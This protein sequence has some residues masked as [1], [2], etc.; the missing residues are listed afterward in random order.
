MRPYDPTITYLGTENP[1]QN[2]DDDTGY[3]SL[4]LGRKAF[5]I[6]DDVAAMMLKSVARGVSKAQVFENV[7]EIA[8]KLATSRLT[9]D[10]KVPFRGLSSVTDDALPKWTSARDAESYIRDLRS[11]M[12]GTD[13]RLLGRLNNVYKINRSLAGA[14]QKGENKFDLKLSLVNHD[15]FYQKVMDKYGID[16]LPF[17]KENSMAFEFFHEFGHADVYYNRELVPKLGTILDES[18]KGIFTTD[19]LGAYR[20]FAEEKYA[21]I[22]AI[23]KMHDML[24]IE[25]PEHLTRLYEDAERRLLET[26]RP[27]GGLLDGLRGRT[28]GVS[29]RSRSFSS[30]VKDIGGALKDKIKDVYQQ[31]PSEERVGGF[32]KQSVSDVAE[33]AA[34]VRDTLINKLDDVPKA[35][36]FT[37]DSTLGFLES[38]LGQR[39]F[40]GSAIGATALAGIALINNVSNAVFKSRQGDEDYDPGKGDYLDKGIPFG[41]SIALGAVLGGGTAYLTRNLD[42]QMVQASIKQYGSR[43]KSFAASVFAADQSGGSRQGWRQYTSVT[44]ALAAAESTWTNVKTDVAELTDILARRNDMV[45]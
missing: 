4:N 21:D 18:F 41:S 3:K 10:L 12:E 17:S 28:S 31:L 33:G 44:G 27:K 20:N 34:T 7:G 29:P 37:L 11:F 42:V 1:Y 5:M 2:D 45:R 13:K 26:S 14:I 25:H 15:E 38:K 6:G 32:L 43:A 19:R 36:S 8:L 23:R 30:D 22:F 40:V 39:M 35:T 24:D 16:S 9:S